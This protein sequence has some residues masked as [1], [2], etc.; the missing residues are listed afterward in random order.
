VGILFPPVELSKKKKKPD[1]KRRLAFGN[2]GAC[3]FATPIIY[4]VRW[5]P[6][7]GATVQKKN[8][9]SRFACPTVHGIAAHCTSHTLPHADNAGRARARPHGPHERRTTRA[10]APVR[11]DRQ[12]SIGQAFPARTM[13][14]RGPHG[15][16]QHT[17]PP[18]TS[19][20][21]RRSLNQKGAIRP[22]A[23]TD[24]DAPAPRHAPINSAVER[25]RSHR[26]TP[27][28][29]RRHVRACVPPDIALPARARR[30]AGQYGVRLGFAGR[31][32]ASVLTCKQTGFAQLCDAP[33]RGDGA[34]H[35]SLPYGPWRP[36]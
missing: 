21:R 12:P 5:S 8:V 29:R 34:V 2:S 23:A 31:Q 20:R 15:A 7:C 16:P 26:R 14:T 13:A 24:A 1:R 25:S 3:L 17:A 30:P 18:A 27:R 22:A 10:P 11:S 35:V 9:A 4:L 19:R 36:A 32:A 28:A 6:W 33:P